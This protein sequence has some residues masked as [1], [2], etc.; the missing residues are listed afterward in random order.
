VLF[1]NRAKIGGFNESGAY[2]KGSYW[3]STKV[4]GYAWVQQ[5]RYGYQDWGSTGSAYSLR[6]VCG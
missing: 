1:N 4:N 5:F 3:S 6:C 2:T